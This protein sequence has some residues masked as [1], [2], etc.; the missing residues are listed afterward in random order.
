MLLPLQEYSRRSAR[1][2]VASFVIAAVAAAPPLPADA[3]GVAESPAPALSVRDLSPRFLAF[4]DTAVAEDADPDRRF[5]LWKELYNFA[6]LPPVPERDRMARELLDAAWPKYPEVLERIRAGAAGMEPRPEET[7][8]E[9]A[10]RLELDRPFELDLLVYVGGLEHNAFFAATG[11]TPTVAL[12]VESEPERRRRTMAHEFTHAVHHVLSGAAGGWERSIGTTALQEGL[13]MRIA[14]AMYPDEPVEAF[15][16]H[17]DG[18]LAEAETR[19]PEILS[20]LREHLEARDSASV[21]R[22]TMGQ[23][24]TGLE[25]EA[26][27]AGWLAVGWLLEHGHTPA[28]LARIPEAD[29]PA[30]IR[31]AIDA[32]LADDA[33]AVA[34]RQEMLAFESRVLGTAVE[35]PVLLPAGYSP[36]GRYPVIY[37][38]LGPVY[39]G[40]SNRLARALAAADG[41][42]AIAV[43]APSV[44]TDSEA[45]YFRFLA[46]ELVP[47]VEARYAARAERE[48]RW[49][50]GFSWGANLAGALAVAYPQT[51][52]RVAA[53]SPGW[54]SWDRERQQ[55]GERFTDRALAGIAA[56]E[57]DVWPRFWFVWGN[58]NEDA[59]EVESRLNGARVLAALRARG[60][61][62]IDAG[63][64]PGGH[65]AG[66]IDGSLPAALAWLAGEGPGG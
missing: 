15:V 28:S 26:Y 48:A 56:T 2:I 13:A 21:L 17:R 44:E 50:L 23:G 66:L 41:P 32:L 58:S 61:L 51:F 1:G 39:F 49:L 47:A 54:M 8:A 64:V 18:W 33:T 57:A 29:M 55:I 53:Q 31:G 65:D 35:V 11:G 42:A 45:T 52:S 12:P 46:E 9:V 43:G 62:A 22:F 6:A 37:A 30:A 10:R 60:A 38:L 4:Y 40:Q 16:E 20:G 7:L 3:S 25:R 19:R 34:A 14:A 24:T 36:E 59:W 63:T 27:F 5:A